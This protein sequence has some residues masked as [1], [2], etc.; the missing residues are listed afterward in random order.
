ME[1]HYKVKI[2]ENNV[3]EYRNVMHREF[4]SNNMINHGM[5]QT[6]EQNRVWVLMSQFRD[7]TKRDQVEGISQQIIEL[8]DEWQS[9]GKFI[10]SGPLDDNKTGMAIFEATEEDAHRFYDRYDKICS[11]I[12]E[13]HLYQWESIPFL[14]ML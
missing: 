1:Y 11:G 10:W 2:L 9:N 14:S 12:L 13:Y 7:D 5:S 3:L 6:T 8:V 4:N